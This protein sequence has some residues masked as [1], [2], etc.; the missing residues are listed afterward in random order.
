MITTESFRVFGE[1]SSFFAHSYAFFSSL[2]V[3]STIKNITKSQ[4]HP[5]NMTVFTPFF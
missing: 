4:I 5:K 1:K 2:L 3:P